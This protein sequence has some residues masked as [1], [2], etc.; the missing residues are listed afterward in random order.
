MKYKSEPNLYV[1]INNKYV[2]RVTGKKGFSFDSD[3]VYETDNELLIKVLSQNFTID[4][5]SNEENNSQGEEIKL[6]N[7]KKCEFTCKTQ[8]EILK[9]YK[10]DHPKEG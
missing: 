1:K 7:C 2:Q 9:H 4:E 6:K 5:Q 8:G 3:G 10:E